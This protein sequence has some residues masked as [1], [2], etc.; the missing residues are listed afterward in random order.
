[1]PLKRHQKGHYFEFWGIRKE[2][3][4]WN[5]R[6]YELKAQSQSWTTEPSCSVTNGK[7]SRDKQNPAETSMPSVW[8]KPEKVFECTE[9]C[10]HKVRLS[11]T[12]PVDSIHPDTGHTFFNT[13][14][15][16]NTGWYE[17]VYHSLAVWD[18]VYCQDDI[19]LVTVNLRFLS[20]VETILWIYF[21]Y[22]PMYTE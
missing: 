19:F 5:K 1:M 14:F 2:C 15:V 17:S 3:N 12:C 8:T 20:L 6:I 13:L 7:Q 21:C 9:N 11:S 4:C 16:I 18:S 22:L 10:A